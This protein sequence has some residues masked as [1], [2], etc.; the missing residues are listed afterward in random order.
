MVQPPWH[1]PSSRPQV[2]RLQRHGEKPNVH[3]TRLIHQPQPRHS[4]QPDLPPLPRR[5]RRRRT[6]HLR[7]PL[8]RLHPRERERERMNTHVCPA[9][10]RNRE[11]I[12]SL[13]CRL[14]D[15]QSLVHTWL[16][17]HF[18]AW[19]AGPFVHVCWWIEDCAGWIF[20]CAYSGSWTEIEDA[21][22][23]ADEDWLN[24]FQRAIVEERILPLP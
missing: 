11:R 13:S 1:H 10:F 20:A 7:R 23:F 4:L 21:W 22:E 16:D 15:I 3:G 8:H 6:H 17:R 12:I 9:R 5:S 14:M 24:D 18:P 2:P 19:M